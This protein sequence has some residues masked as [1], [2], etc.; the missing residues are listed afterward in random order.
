MSIEI[1]PDINPIIGYISV[2]FPFAMAEHITAGTAEYKDNTKSMPALA[3]SWYLPPLSNIIAAN[4]EIIPR[5][6]PTI[7]N[8]CLG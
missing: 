5:I 1:I 4:I 6:N 7:D 3:S 2:F 8:V